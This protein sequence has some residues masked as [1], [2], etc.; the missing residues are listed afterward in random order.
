MTEPV[1]VF[2][3]LAVRRRRERAGAAA[4]PAAFLAE[5]IA[6][7]LCDRLDDL[8]RSFANV[9]VIGA[10]GGRLGA[11]AAGRPGVRMLA[12]AD[13]SEALARRAARPVVVADEEALPFAAGSFDL[14]LGGFS[15]HAVNDLPG[16]LVQIRGALKPGGLFLAAMAGGGTLH[17]L[18]RVLIEAEAEQEGG[19]SPRV[20]PFA[21]VPDA[22]ALLQ[23]AGF[24]LPVVD[25]D[26]ITVT[27]ASP[28]ALMADLR[29]MGEAN[30][31][32]QRLRRPTRRATLLAAAA[33]YRDLFADADGR[34]PATF[35]IL[36]LTGWAPGPDQQRPL[37]PGGAAARLADALGGEEHSAGEAANPR[38]GR[39]DRS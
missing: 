35:R 6:G 5:E 31:L 2:D 3:R 30:A 11:L 37:R 7:R 27:W 13:L 39:A 24:A 17:E 22:G 9:L 28:L 25:G 21:D 18:R 14:V 26:T 29:A 10:L 19:A 4:E 8:R 1:E 36:T 23:R 16:A 38:N 15:L 34:V 33:R 20:A 12:T 32:S